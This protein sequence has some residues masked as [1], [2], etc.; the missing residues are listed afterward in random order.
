MGTL[1]QLTDKVRLTG[2]AYDD[3]ASGVRMF[4]RASLTKPFKVRFKLTRKV[5]PSTTLSAGSFN[6]V[7]WVV[8]T[9]SAP[10][11]IPANWPP[12]TPTRDDDIASYLKGFRFAPGNV[13]TVGTADSNKFRMQ[14]YNG[15]GTRTQYNND[16]IVNLG[17]N[18]EQE[19]ELSA[20]GT[21]A[22]LAAID[23][24]LSVSYSSPVI[25]GMST[26]YLTLFTSYGM[27]ADWGDFRRIS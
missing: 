26:G 4:S 24:G 11:P 5:I 12:T 3:L 25:G 10:T 2:G 8:A 16:T 13:N 19:M 15:D 14:T 17:L 21:T 18:V 7:G 22:T 6:L 1:T 9:S 23:L 20:T 27:S